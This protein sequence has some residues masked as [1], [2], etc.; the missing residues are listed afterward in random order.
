MHRR[1]FFVVSNSCGIDLRNHID[2]RAG[3]AGVT[4]YVAEH[5]LDAAKKAGRMIVREADRRGRTV[6]GDVVYLELAEIRKST[7]SREEPLSKSGVSDII[8]KFRNHTIDQESPLLHKEVACY[9]FERKP[10][11]EPRQIARVFKGVS[12]SASYDYT[13]CAVSSDECAVAASLLLL[14]SSGGQ[15]QAAEPCC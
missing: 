6:R 12:Y 10:I 15:R 2:L 9:R 4:R 14:R 3:T 7:A 8:E 1:K 13:I 5:P 11:P